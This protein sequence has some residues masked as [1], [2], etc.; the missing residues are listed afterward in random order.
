MEC[1]IIERRT[2]THWYRSNVVQYRYRDAHEF[3]LKDLQ[4]ATGV[5]A[6]RIVKAT[7]DLEHPVFWQ[8]R[9][10]PIARVEDES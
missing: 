3:A 4:E 6:V 8:E 1:Y 10:A 2:A 9:E 5:L 7:I